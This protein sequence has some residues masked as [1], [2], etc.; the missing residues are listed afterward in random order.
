MRAETKSRIGYASLVLLALVLVAAVMASNSLLRG[1]QVDLTENHLYT[2]APGTKAVLEDIPEPINLYLFY[3]D[4]EASNV[5]FLRSYAGRVREMLDELA[6]D[7]NGKLKVKVID[8]EPFSE[9]EDRATQFGLQSVNLGTQGQNIFFGVAGTNSVGDTQKIP[10]L[11]P[12]KEAFLEYDLTR[13]IYSLAHPKKPVIGLLSGLPISG[14]FNPQTQRSSQAWM[15]TQQV[16]QLFDL[17]TLSANVDK[18]DKDI[19]VLWLVHPQNLSNKT[20]Y[21]IDQFVLGGGRALVF[22]DPL[23]QIAAPRSPMAGLAGMQRASSNLARLFKAWGVQYSP[24][25]VVTDNVHALSVN[26]G[27]GKPP[28][29]HIGLVGIDKGSMDQKDVIT[30]GLDSIN[31][32]DAGYFTK[33]PKA[34]IKFTPLI[35]SSKQSALMP[36]I[37][38]QFVQ[39]PNQLLNNF[40]PSGKTYTIAARLEGHIDTAFPD[41]PPANDSADSGKNKSTDAD[42]SA[43]KAATVK[44]VSTAAAA[45]K[46]QTKQDS[47][48]IKSTDKANIV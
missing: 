20:L 4:R 33:A 13:M 2:L 37:K 24:S 12:N 30:A 18:I 1:V 46:P 6:A 32:A 36:S 11:D 22:V 23:A 39:D 16:R 14:G 34:K 35:M 47:R 8:P 25:E 44:P 5:P 40:V 27:Y 9:E 28:V 10:F 17:R 26:A 29:R 3:S 41:G 45:A 43:S 48:Q 7:S 31:F 15:I 19:D 38:M 21:A 42:S